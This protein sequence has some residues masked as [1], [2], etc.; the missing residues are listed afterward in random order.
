[1]HR[2]LSVSRVGTLS[3]GGPRG[4][5]DKTAIRPEMFK[6]RAPNGL[7]KVIADGVEA[8]VLASAEN[9]VQQKGSELETAQA[10]ENSCHDWHRPK[11]M[12]LIEVRSQFQR[13]IGHKLQHHR[14]QQA[15]LMYLPEFW[16]VRHQLE[17]ARLLQQQ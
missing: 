7:P 17:P 15:V 13:H 1:M 6:L 16:V 9:S 12:S 2:R 10:D 4:S 14:V 5:G 11:G 8:P 3:C